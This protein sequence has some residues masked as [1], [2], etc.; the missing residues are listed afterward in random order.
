MKLTDKEKEERNKS[1]RTGV[2]KENLYV[3]RDCDC[4]DDQWL[5]ST[6]DMKIAVQEF[7][8]SFKKVC[9]AGDIFDCYL[10]DNGDESWYDRVYG[11]E[12][13]S[14]SWAYDHLVDIKD[15]DKE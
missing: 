5:F 6:T 13:M 12:A 1:K 8:N 2:L 4:D 10:D 11:I 15:V 3:K 14:E 7:K 9:S